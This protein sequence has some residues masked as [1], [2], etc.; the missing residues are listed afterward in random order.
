M[1]KMTKNNYEYNK[2]KKNVEEIENQI[3]NEVYSLYDLTNSEIKVIE[4]SLK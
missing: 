1:K 2:L 3:D 4:E